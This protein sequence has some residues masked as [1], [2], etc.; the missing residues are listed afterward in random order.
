MATMMLNAILCGE[1]NLK[2]I[3]QIKLIFPHS[4]YG[5]LFIMIYTAYCKRLVM[6]HL[7]PPQIIW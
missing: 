2:W 3:K 1:S 6:H 7:Q 4:Y 5:L